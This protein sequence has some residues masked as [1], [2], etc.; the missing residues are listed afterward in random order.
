MRNGGL[1]DA[2]G[3]PW[4]ATRRTRHRRRSPRMRASLVVAQG[5]EPIACLAWGIRKAQRADSTGVAR[6]R[7]YFLHTKEGSST[8]R[9]AR[10]TTERQCSLLGGPFLLLPRWVFTALRRLR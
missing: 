6:L 10:S 9:P 8:G 7:A 1:S 2:S 3:R 4:I 5:T